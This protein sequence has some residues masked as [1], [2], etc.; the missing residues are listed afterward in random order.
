MTTTNIY[1]E[2]INE[3]RYIAGKQLVM[4]DLGSEDWK[5]YTEAVDALAVAAWRDLK[6][7]EGAKNVV[8]EAVT[9]LFKFFEVDAKATSAMQRRLQ[10]CCITTKREQ[11]VQYKKAQSA[12]RDA[13]KSLALVTEER[14]ADPEN[15]DLCNAVTVAEALVESRAQTV[16]EL[17]AQPHNVWYVHKPMLDASMVHASAKC[18]KLV[19]DTLADIIHER[20]LMSYEELKAEADALAA[21]RKARK[22]AK[23]AAA[24]KSENA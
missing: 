8:G 17:A 5:L 10:L 14:D 4:A 2:T 15:E 13:K 12:L 23:K 18:R 19:E 21:E 24:E 3:N 16:E 6:R 9:D 1:A 11:S 7:R 22:K 20:S